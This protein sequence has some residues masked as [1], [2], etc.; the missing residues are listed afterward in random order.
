MPMAFSTVS[1]FL[2]MGH[3]GI[4]VWVAYGTVFLVLFIQW[5]IIK[6]E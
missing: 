4:Y 5:W 1:E 3:H 6:R 2:K